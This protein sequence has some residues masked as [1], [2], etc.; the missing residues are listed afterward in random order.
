MKMTRKVSLCA[1][2]ALITLLLAACAG[3]PVL[4]DGE[5]YFEG[6]IAFEHA[7]SCTVS[8]ILCADGKS[9]RDTTIVQKNLS[10]TGTAKGRTVREKA[11][12]SVI[13]FGGGQPDGQGYL[14]LKTRAV[15]LRLNIAADGVRGEMDYSYKSKPGDKPTIDLFIGTYP[16]EMADKTDSLEAR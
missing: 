16:F 13:G 1:L 10:Y 3:A 2:A 5:R 8:Y 11:G 12:T 14:E 7:E 4:Q 9:V 6:D 15:T